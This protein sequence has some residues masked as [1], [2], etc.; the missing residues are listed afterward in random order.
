MTCYN[1]STTPVISTVLCRVSLCPVKNRVAPIAEIS[2]IGQIRIT[3]WYKTSVCGGKSDPCGRAPSLGEA[4]WVH[5]LAIIGTSL[6]RAE[7]ESHILAFV[8]NLRD[9][10]SL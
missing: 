1:I 4:F 7:Q 8:E 9:R 2:T 6:V 3:T 5:H 10:G